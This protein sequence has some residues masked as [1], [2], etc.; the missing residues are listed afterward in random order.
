MHPLSTQEQSSYSFIAK[1]LLVLRISTLNSQ[2]ITQF[3]INNYMK[4]SISYSILFY[5]E[6]FLV[7]VNSNFST[8]GQDVILVFMNFRD[9]ETG[10]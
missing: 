10:L 8:I 1:F 6:K 7:L 2:F 9:R 4:T 3:N 5:V